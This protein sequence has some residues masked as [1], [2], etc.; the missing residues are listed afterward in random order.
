M[1]LDLKD[2]FNIGNNQNNK[3]LKGGESVRT[4]NK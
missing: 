1:P 2:T 4:P 3:L